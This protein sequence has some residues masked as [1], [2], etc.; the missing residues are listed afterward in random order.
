MLTLDAAIFFVL[1]CTSCTRPR[2]QHA[3]LVGVF[4]CVCVLVRVPA[5]V[6]VC[7]HRTPAQTTAS[8]W[9]W[10]SGTSSV[11]S[12]PNASSR[13]WNSPSGCQV[14]PP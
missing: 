5:C 1:F 2:L 4:L 6:Y 11:S 12:P 10:V 8:S 7:V 14:S 3:E 13:L 9:I